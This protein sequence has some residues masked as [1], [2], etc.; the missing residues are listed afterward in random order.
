LIVVTSGSGGVF[1]SGIPI[2]KIDSSLNDNE[3]IVNLYRDFTQLKYVRISS[4]KKDV[5]LDASNKKIFEENNE[6]ILKMNNQKEDIKILQQQKAI[7]EEIKSKLEIENTNLKEKL[8]NIQTKL[9]EKNKKINKEKADKE[10]VEFLN[11]NL[12][13]GKKC[14][15][16]FFKP[17]LFMVNTNEYRA[18]VLNKG[19]I[20]KARW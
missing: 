1:K 12:L 10:N 7:D 11:L 9:A 14:K 5:K 17:N 6:Q 16:T 20:K 19:P 13:F 2:G 3:I 18:C 8:I 4:Q 15:K